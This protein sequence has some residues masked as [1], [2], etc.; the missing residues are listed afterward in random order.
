MITSFVQLASA[1]VVSS[2]RGFYF[3]MPCEVLEFMGSNL[4]LYPQ[5]MTGGAQAAVE[6]N[7]Y[8]KVGGEEVIAAFSLVFGQAGLIAFTIHAVSQAMRHPSL[9]EDTL[10]TP[11]R[12]A[13]R[14]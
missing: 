1:Q 4:E 6:A 5:C 8:T 11:I 2:I 9:V 7:I 10:L 3:I 14:C 12:V 13:C